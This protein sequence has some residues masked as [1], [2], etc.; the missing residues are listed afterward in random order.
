MTKIPGIYNNKGY[1]QIRI[2]PWPKSEKPKPYLESGFGCWCLEHIKDAEKRLRVLRDEVESGKFAKKLE[3]KEILFSD[4][5]ELFY[6]LHYIEKKRTKAS[7][8]NAKSTGN[9]FKALWPKAYLHH[10]TA[11][12]IK[13]DLVLKTTVVKSTLKRQLGLLGAMFNC[14]ERW[15]K[16]EEIEKLKLPDSNPVAA[17]RLSDYNLRES[18]IVRKHLEVGELQRYKD[19]CLENDPDLWVAS[20]AAMTTLLRHGDLDKMAGRPSIIGTASKT[21]K[22]FLLPGAVPKIVR[23]VNARVR[24]ERARAA[25]GIIWF[26]WHWWRNQGGKL[27]RILGIDEKTVNE[28]YQHATIQQTREYTGDPE[29]AAPAMEKVRNF[30]DNLSHSEVRPGA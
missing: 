2:W 14:L 5:W 4:A 27:M 1:V 29:W 19:W 7:R 28:I 12:V 26:H 20:Y 23:L 9:I 21:G 24:W 16:T 18:V 3:Q 11:K 22:V 13:E 10:F 30:L 17:I 15:V 6:R 25:C 8:L